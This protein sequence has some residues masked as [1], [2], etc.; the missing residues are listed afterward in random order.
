MSP[1]NTRLCWPLT[2]I[3]ECRWLMSIRTGVILAA[4][5]GTRLLPATKAQPKEMLPLVDRPIIQ[6][7]VEEAVSA[8][9]NRLI[10]VTAGSKR[11]L[12]D[13]FDRDPELE[14]LL[15]GKGDHARLEEVRRLANLAEIAFVRQKERRG[16][17][18]ALL[19]AQW[20]IG[21]EPFALYFPD[22]VILSE[23]PVTR[24]LLEVHER[25]QGSVLAVQEVSPGEVSHYGVIDA[26]AMDGGVYRVRGMVEKPTAEE[27]PSNLI[28]VGR[29]ILTPA[30]FP[31][32]SRTPMGQ[33][34][35][36]WLTDALGELIRRES[37]YA[38]A[39]EGT[40]FDTGQPLGL[41]KA[42]LTVAMTRQ[43]MAAELRTYLR[44][45]VF[46]SKEA[47]ISAKGASRDR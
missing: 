28:S 16:T 13:H 38:L 3:V 42:S 21:D 31:I 10:I 34:G 19:Q 30:I 17:G 9:I 1:T 20:L 5:Y 33:G 46:D 2:A 4:G 40:R 26:E 47:N 37:V 15:A 43:D 11:S 24:Q 36:I 7:I 12:E 45:L 8:G 35:E 25:F 41:L 14:R 23:V 6:Y 22:D 29:F 18:H 39:F 44:S 32:L 27:A